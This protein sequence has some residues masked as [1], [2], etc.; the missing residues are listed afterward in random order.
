MAIA[1]PTS[2]LIGYCRLAE[3]WNVDGRERQVDY[4]PK[5][6][7]VDEDEGASAFRLGERQLE[8]YEA[9]E[10][11]ADERRS[12]YVQGIDERGD[13]A[14]EEGGGVVG[15]GSGA[16]RGAGHVWSVDAVAG[17]QGGHDPPPVEGVVAGTVQHHGRTFARGKI[18]DGHPVDLD[19][20]PL[21]GHIHSL[22]PVISAPLF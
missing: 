21:Y 18:A 10:R 16:V 11:V 17:C 14:L 15:G 13:E 20:L 5:A 6:G 1:S 2:P 9:P 3:A 12:S 8:G 4:A 7:A 22:G 19:V